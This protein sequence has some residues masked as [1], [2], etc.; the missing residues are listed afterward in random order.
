MSLQRDT[1]QSKSFRSNSFKTIDLPVLN[2]VTLL[3]RQNQFDSPRCI[4]LQREFYHLQ[5]SPPEGNSN[6][7]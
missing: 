5:A 4:I 3:L 2:N 1:G 6:F 7:R